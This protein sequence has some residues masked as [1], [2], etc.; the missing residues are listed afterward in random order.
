MSGLKKRQVKGV[1][2]L[3][4]LDE[5]QTTG[6]IRVYTQRLKMPQSFV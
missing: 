4:E 1:G 6:E 3:R 2:A 5:P